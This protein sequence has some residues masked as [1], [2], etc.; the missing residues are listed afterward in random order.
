[1]PEKTD[2][3]NAL[4]VYQ[5]EVSQSERSSLSVLAALIQ[6]G[7]SVLDLGL[8]SGALGRH[9]TGLGWPAPD[10]LTYNPAEAELARPF[11]GRV[12]VANLEDADLLSIFNGQRYD[13]IVCAD[14]LEHLTQPNHVLSK[15]GALL[16]SG[17]KLLISVPNAG[18][19]GLVAELLQGEFR[20]RDEGLLDRTHLRFFTR[21]SL[22]RFMLENGWSLDAL[23]VIESSLKESEFR[24]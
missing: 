24:T 4:H 20:Y 22:Q 3:P 21:R 6:P 8:G 7:A 12:E 13:Y 1:M 18:Y 2:S 9:L 19:A 16:E 10:G 14:V 11:Y 15:C 17:G 5:R 23:E